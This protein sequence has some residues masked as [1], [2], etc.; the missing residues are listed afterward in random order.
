LWADIQR[1]PQGKDR[2]ILTAAWPEWLAAGRIV[3]LGSGDLP[4]YTL[5]DGA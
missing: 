4:R 5:S 3:E 2:P 1:C